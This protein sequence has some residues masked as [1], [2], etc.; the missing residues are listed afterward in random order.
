VSLKI[1]VGGVINV[2]LMVMFLYMCMFFVH[3]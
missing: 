2:G 1:E 3:K